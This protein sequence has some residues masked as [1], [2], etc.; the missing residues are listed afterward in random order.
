MLLNNGTKPIKFRY[1][2]YDVCSPDVLPWIPLNVYT[3]YDWKMEHQVMFATKKKSLEWDCEWYFFINLPWIE[4]KWA[5]KN[6]KTRRFSWPSNNSILHVTLM[7]VWSMT[8]SNILF[9][10]LNVFQLKILQKRIISVVIKHPL[11][12]WSSRVRQAVTNNY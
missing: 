5:E 10:F 12:H 11:K 8:M 3:I 4:L 7:R 9:S 1:F 6:W 2:L